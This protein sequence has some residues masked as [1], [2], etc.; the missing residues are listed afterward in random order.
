MSKFWNYVTIFSYIWNQYEKCIQISPNMPGIGLVLREIRFRIENLA[1]TKPSFTWKNNGRVRGVIQVD[2]RVVKLQPW[3]S[4]VGVWPCLCTYLN[5]NWILRYTMLWCFAFHRTLYSVIRWECIL[6]VLLKRKKEIMHVRISNQ[7]IFFS[8]Y[9]SMV[10]FV[11]N[12][13]EIP[14]VF[15]YCPLDTFIE[16]YG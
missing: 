5:N 13:G 16:C 12:S 7:V 8:Y 14:E 9:Y 2:D 4:D 10:Y 15:F 1:K 3:C 6:S 11:F